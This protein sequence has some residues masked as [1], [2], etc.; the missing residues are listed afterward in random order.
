[1]GSRAVFIHVQVPCLHSVLFDKSSI[2]DHIPKFS[3]TKHLQVWQSQNSFHAYHKLFPLL[4]EILFATFC[5]ILAFFLHYSRKVSFFTKWFLYHFFILNDK[6]IFNHW[7]CNSQIFII[8]TNNRGV[9]HE[10][11]RWMKMN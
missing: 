7:G 6:N 1:M 8:W 3:S 9:G 11:Y 10:F 4:N 2:H 5:I